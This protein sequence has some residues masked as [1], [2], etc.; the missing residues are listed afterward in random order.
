[1]KKASL[2]LLLLWAFSSCTYALKVQNIN[3]YYASYSAGVKKHRIGIQV[4]AR[5]QI[6]EKHIEEVVIA[7]RATGNFEILFPYNPATKADLI[8][9]VSPIVKYDGSIANYFISWPGVYIFMPGWN[10]Y[11]YYANLDTNYSIKKS[12]NQVLKQGVIPVN[13]KINQ[14]DIGRTW[15]EGVDW[16]LT[17]GVTSLIAG[18]FYT[19]FDDDIQGDLFRNYGQAYGKFIANKLSQ[20]I[21]AVEQH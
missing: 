21:I 12:N 17:L 7:L 16:L 18:F 2:L 10:G 8:I 6:E 1:M 4:Q 20:E 3:D 5:N 19:S 13:Y 15:V 14:S 11:K 9:E